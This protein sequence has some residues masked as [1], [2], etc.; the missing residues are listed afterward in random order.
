MI[1]GLI[2]DIH[3]NIFGFRAV[4]DQLKDAD[5]ILC[6][7]D[8][9]GYYTFPNEVLGLLKEKNVKFIRGNFDQFI[10]N[11][12][13]S[14]DLIQESIDFTRRVITPENLEFLS[15]APSQLNLTLDNK[16]ILVFHGS[17]WQA[18]EYINPDFDH[19]EKFETFE[20]DLIVLGHTHMP[21][22]HN[23]SSIKIVNP[24]SCGQPRDRDSR[25]SF[26][27]YDTKTGQI[28][29]KRVE[30]N[31]VDVINAVKKYDLSPRLIEI[32]KRT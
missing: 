4:L 30:Y 16:K 15:Q 23:L 8:I 26:A 3:S 18:D 1:I 10:I 14:N 24:G 12:Q 5:L 20:A 6:A 17:P 32:L 29:L 7:G 19:F 28:E 13:S 25:A 2:S 21:M 27:V 11:G 22:V 9:T 31:Y